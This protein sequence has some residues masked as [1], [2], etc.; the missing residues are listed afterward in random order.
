MYRSE[1][2]MYPPKFIVNYGLRIIGFV[3]DVKHQNITGITEM[4]RISVCS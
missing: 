2:Q 1:I 3:F 4:Y